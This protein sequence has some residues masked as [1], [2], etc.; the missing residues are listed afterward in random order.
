MMIGLKMDTFDPKASFDKVHELLFAEGFTFCKQTIQP[1]LVAMNIFEMM[2]GDSLY[3][4][5]G[6]EHTRYSMFISDSDN[7]SLTL[8]PNVE[9]SL[10]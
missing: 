6:H 9:D 3:V 7:V 8:D 5:Y 2:V 4:R 10:I 1:L